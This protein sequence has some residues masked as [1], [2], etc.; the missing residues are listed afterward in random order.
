MPL[1]STTSC[2]SAPSSTLGCKG[3][4]GGP[5]APASPGATESLCSLCSP[6]PP[7]Q[8]V[9]WSGRGA[10]STIRCTPIPAAGW[11]RRQRGAGDNLSTGTSMHQGVSPLLLSNAAGVAAG[12]VGFGGIPIAAVV[13]ASR[14]RARS[15][16]GAGRSSHHRLPHHTAARHCLP[17]PLVRDRC[18]PR[19]RLLTAA[20]RNVG[21]VP[22]EILVAAAITHTQGAIGNG[23]W[24]AAPR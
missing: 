18:R 3:G 19:S 5:A 4:P 9:A 14:W 16:R 21:A 12:N 24:R 23:I 15:A 20:Q 6:R 11:Q 2:V 8:D 13:L 1:S 22:Q 17:I 10:P 7:A